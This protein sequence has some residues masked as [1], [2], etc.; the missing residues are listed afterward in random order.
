MPKFAANVSMLFSEVEQH[1]SFHSAGL[2]GKETHRRTKRTLVSRWPMR[3]PL[4]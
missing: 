1:G 4:T 3:E 2:L